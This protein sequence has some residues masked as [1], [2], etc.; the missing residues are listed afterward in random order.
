MTQKEFN[1]KYKNFLREGF[2]GLG[3]DDPDVILFLDNIFQTLTLIPGFQYIKI[4]LKFG[5]ARF[6]SNIQSDLNYLIEE[7]INEILKIKNK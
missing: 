3:F 1:E 5:M 6:Y 7:K 2:Y 4:K